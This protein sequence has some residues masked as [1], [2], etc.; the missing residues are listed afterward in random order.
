[1]ETCVS[2][3][4]RKVYVDGGTMCVRIFKKYDGD[5]NGINQAGDSGKRLT[6]SYTFTYF[7][8][9]KSRKQFGYKEELLLSQT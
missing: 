4:T 1:V 6:F 3:S 2:K 5:L 7:G 8:Y 9:I